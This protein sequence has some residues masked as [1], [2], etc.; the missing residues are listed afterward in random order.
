MV[1]TGSS[2]QSTANAIKL[3]ERFPDMLACTAGV[4]PHEAARAPADVIKRLEQL[5]ASPHVRAIGEC[6]LDFNRDFSGHE[7]Q[8]AIFEA[9]VEL[10]CRLNKPLF[11]HER[12]AFSQLLEVLDRIGAKYQLPKI[13]IHCFTGNESEL[14]EYM[15]RGYY[16]GITGFIAK[17]S[18]GE[19]LRRFVGSVVPLERLMIE[20]DC[21]YMWPDMDSR[22]R[23]YRNRNE[24]CTLPAV[25]NI[26]AEHCYEDSNPHDIARA[27][28]M[29]ACEFFGLG[30]P[31]VSEYPPPGLQRTTFHNQTESEQKSF[32]LEAT[33]TLSSPREK[34][35]C[36]LPSAEQN[37]SSD[38]PSNL[39]HLTFL[40]H[41]QGLHNVARFSHGYTVPKKD[42]FDARLTDH[43][44]KQCIDLTDA[45]NAATPRLGLV[46]CSPLRR[47]LQTAS[48]MLGEKRHG[49]MPWV[50]LECVRE[51]H[52]RNICDKRN[53]IS[54]T[55]KD[56]PHV[57]F[58]TF[59]SDEDVLWQ[60]RRESDE[61]VTARGFELLDW[62]RDTRSESHV[63]VVSHDSFLTTLF[64]SCLELLNTE[65]VDLKYH[66]LAN[67]E[68][69]ELLVDFAPKNDTG[70]GTGTN[71]AART[72]PADAQRQH[73][74]Q[75]SASPPPGLGGSR[76][77][78]VRTTANL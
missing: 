47:A 62:L 23:K 58:S 74:R 29:T 28:T 9:Q 69:L 66:Y 71:S 26:L 78:P 73:R 10:A 76:G 43:G 2:L 57:D 72:P 41:A 4:H 55:S 34:Y 50:A 6:G 25:V 48:L 21:P 60:K 54:A 27:T 14:R 15:V 45:F 19:A 8:L 33:P 1:I 11:I 13:V 36:C 49:G 63:L 37:A 44:E 39:K 16:I 53:L 77:S 70:T 68:Y 12:D 31:V 38:L 52:G 18:R 61:S 30:P 35:R 75:H 3:C 32:S 22:L 59:S 17:K 56:F 5:A 40:R 42:L 24:P 51:R 7:S 67:C 20:T 64:R 46:V 65:A